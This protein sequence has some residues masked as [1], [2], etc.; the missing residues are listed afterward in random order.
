MRFSSSLL[1]FLSLDIYSSRTLAFTVN[2]DTA[3]SLNSLKSLGVETRRIGTS[4][5]KVASQDI[6]VTG[7]QRKKTKEVRSSFSH[8]SSRFILLQG[9]SLVLIFYDFVLYRNDFSK[10]VKDYRFM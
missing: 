4:S 5:L 9:L 1:L 7:L 8:E 10:P 6:E 3:R 2:H